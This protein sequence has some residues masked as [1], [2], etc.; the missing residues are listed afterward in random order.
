ML[1]QVTSGY[2]MSGLFISGKVTLV[3]IRSS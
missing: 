2:N 3:Q 1:G